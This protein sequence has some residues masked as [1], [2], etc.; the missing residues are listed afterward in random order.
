MHDV[1]VLHNC[2]DAEIVTAV[3]TDENVACVI[4]LAETIINKVL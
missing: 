4:T 1:S 3:S 2:R